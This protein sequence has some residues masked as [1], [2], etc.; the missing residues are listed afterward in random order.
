MMLSREWAFAS[1]PAKIL[2]ENSLYFTKRAHTQRGDA[3]EIKHSHQF[4]TLAVMMER[5][6]GEKSIYYHYLRGLPTDFA[7]LG[8]QRVWMCLSVSYFLSLPLSVFHI[9]SNTHTR[10]LLTHTHSLSLSLALSVANVHVCVCQAACSLTVRKSGA[11]VIH[12]QPSS[13]VSLPLSFPC[14]TR[15]PSNVCLSLSHIRYSDRVSLGHH[16]PSALC[17]SHTR[18]Q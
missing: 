6:K 14:L 2:M 5:E 3:I 13:P 15:T 8:T 4:I 1:L 11:K 16:S 12:T 10:S 9:R 7:T 17:L 18:V